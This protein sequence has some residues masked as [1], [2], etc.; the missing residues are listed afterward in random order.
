MELGKVFCSLLFRIKAGLS[1]IDRITKAI[2]NDNFG[3]RN[4]EYW[5]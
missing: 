1:I 5:D 4:R 3:V 2:E